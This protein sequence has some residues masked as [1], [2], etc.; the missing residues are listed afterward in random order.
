MRAG[1]GQPRIECLFTLFLLGSLRCMRPPVPRRARPWHAHARANVNRKHEMNARWKGA[2]GP[3][4]AP[5]L[6]HT[7]AKSVGGRRRGEEGRGRGR[8][9]RRRS[10]CFQVGVGFN[11]PYLPF[12][13]LPLGCSVAR[14]SG[15]IQYTLRLTFLLVPPGLSPYVR[16]RESAPGYASEGEG[17]RWKAHARGRSEGGGGG[18]HRNAPRA[19][20]PSSHR[21]RATERPTHAHAWCTVLSAGGSRR[22]RR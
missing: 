1:V 19:L 18:Q 4:Q 17:G 22:R 10:S 12:L 20:A 15:E 5:S 21:E 16:R 3:P 7:P 11:H 8:A 2:R 14:R 13:A 6:T 9:D